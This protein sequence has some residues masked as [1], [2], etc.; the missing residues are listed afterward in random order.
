[1]LGV[2]LLDKC[3]NPKINYTPT[4]IKKDMKREHGITL[5]Y[6]QPWRGRQQAFSVLRGDPTMSY[7]NTNILIYIEKNIFRN[8]NGFKKDK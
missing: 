4:E 3:Q 5:S 6:M 2:M 1:M 8:Y 7:A